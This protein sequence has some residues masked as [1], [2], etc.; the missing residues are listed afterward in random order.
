MEGLADFAIV[1]S[2]LD[3]ANKWGINKLDALRPL[4]TTGDGYHQR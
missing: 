1:H 3:T 4:F 2:Y